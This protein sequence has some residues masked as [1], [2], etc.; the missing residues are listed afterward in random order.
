MTTITVFEIETNGQ[1][2]RRYFT[3][4]DAATF[5]HGYGNGA[6]FREVLY[7][8]VPGSAGSLQ[9]PDASLDLLADAKSPVAKLIRDLG[10]RHQAETDAIRDAVD[11]LVDMEIMAPNPWSYGAKGGHIPLPEDEARQFRVDIRSEYVVDVTGD[12]REQTVEALQG[13]AADLTAAAERLQFTVAA[14]TEDDAE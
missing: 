6:A 10:D 9:Q 1:F 12:I 11:D 13:L 7:Q 3:E 4:R 8:L 5:C 2:V 14:E